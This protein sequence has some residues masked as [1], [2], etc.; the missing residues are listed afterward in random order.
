AVC[1]PAPQLVDLR[2]ARARLRR[3]PARSALELR[4]SGRK[5]RFATPQ[6]TRA[7]IGLREADPQAPRAPSSDRKA[8]AQPR[9]AA[10]ALPRPSAQSLRPRRGNAQALTQPAKAVAHACQARAELRLILLGRANR[11]A[12]A[13][14][15]ALHLPQPFRPLRD[16]R[17]SE[18]AA[19]LLLRR[20]LTL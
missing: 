7:A 16:L 20:D 10:T 5:T 18:D 11:A 6:R 3:G 19:N 4:R 8:P 12:R 9:S 13:R 15:R 1:K 14:E 17:R 2:H